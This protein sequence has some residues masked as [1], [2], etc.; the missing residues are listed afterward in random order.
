MGDAF[1]RYPDVLRGPLTVAE[2]DTIDSLGARGLSAGQVALKI[3]RHPSTVNFALQRLGH[4]GIARRSTRPYM[5]N[6]VLVMPFS[7]AE[8]ELMQALR[9]RGQTCASIAGRLTLHY[10]HPRNAN[11]VLMRLTMLAADAACR[12]AAA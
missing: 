1:N 8:D 10:G 7:E 2:L 9:G 3:N 5:R 12:E 6:G 11:S 4:R